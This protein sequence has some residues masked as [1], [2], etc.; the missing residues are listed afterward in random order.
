MKLG[1]VT[2][3]TPEERLLEPDFELLPVPDAAGDFVAQTRIGNIIHASGTLPWINGGLRFAGLIG[4]T[5]AAEQG[6][7]AF[8]QL[9]LNG[10]SLLKSITGDLSE[11]KRKHRM[12]GAS[13][14]TAHFHDMPRA[15]SGA[16]HLANRVF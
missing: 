10:L 15:L 7:A 9:A 4:G 6:Y 1:N 13:E 14:A 11:I 5:F 16:S 8:Q 2:R 12:G 3:A